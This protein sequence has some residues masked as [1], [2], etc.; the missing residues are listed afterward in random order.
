[1]APKSENGNKTDGYYETRRS[2]VALVWGNPHADSQLHT[3]VPKS[4]GGTWVDYFRTGP[5]NRINSARATT[6]SFY[7]H[8]GFNQ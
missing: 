2:S 7:P 1:M 5:N 3:K 8:K 6:R 4:A